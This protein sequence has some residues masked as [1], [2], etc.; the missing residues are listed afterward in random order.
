MPVQVP[1]EADITHQIQALDILLERFAR[2]SLTRDHEHRARNCPAHLGKHPHEKLDVLLMRHS[3]DVGQE[4][5][6][7]GQAVAG[8]KAVAIALPEAVGGQAGR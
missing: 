1:D 4:R 8:T 3:T 2:R 6:V 7:S 5:P